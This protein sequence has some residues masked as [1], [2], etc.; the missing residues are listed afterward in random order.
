MGF[1]YENAEGGR[2][3]GRDGGRQKARALGMAVLVFLLA[4]CA[5]DKRRA[6]QPKRGN[7]R[8][9]VLTTF[10]LALSK[11]DFATA[12][13]MMSP[14]DRSR[15]LGEDGQVMPGYQERLRA[16]RLTTMAQNPL[17]SIEEG[18]IRGL[19]DL[20]PV[21]DQG[22]PVE[23]MAIATGAPSGNPAIP[24]APAAGEDELD[25]RE[26]RAATD[27]FFRSVRDQQW[28]KALSM[29]NPGERQVFLRS[30]GKIKAAAT[31]RL[32]AIDTSSWEALDMDE[33]KL[34]GVVLI[35][36][37]TVPEGGR[38]LAR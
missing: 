15:L 34:S 18:R 11:R 12:A 21:L 16:L 33:G 2:V 4:A 22:P 19:Y 3:S 9:E 37:A 20:L 1:E 24:A 32:A 36:P 17:I 23:S 35:I 25:R 27:A 30:D 7:D 5:G 6:F 26:L 13:D 28:K 31:R 10:T 29:V 38:T 14:A 8:L